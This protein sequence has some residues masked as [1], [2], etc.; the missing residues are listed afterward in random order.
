VGRTVVANR[1]LAGSACD[2]RRR[3]RPLNS[4]VRPQKMCLIGTESKML[5]RLL[6]SNAN[7]TYAG[8]RVSLWLLGLILFMKL[9]IALGSILNG[10]Y[11]ASVAD[12]IPIDSFT[13]AARQAFLSL[14][15]SLGLCQFMLGLVGVLLLLRYRALVPLFLLALIVEYLARKGINA[16]MPIART[17]DAP[18]GI[19][20]WA[21][22]AVMLLAFGLSVR[23][24]NVPALSEA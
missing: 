15:A 4:V 22:F 2:K 9:A 6:P 8:S 21:I 10:H 14:F 24:S 11:A 5:N 18:V 12:G 7:F 16:Y 23:Q 20:N 19:I 3:G 13:P 1:L 17:G